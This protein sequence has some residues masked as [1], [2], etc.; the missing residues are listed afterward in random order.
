MRQQQLQ[1]AL[2]SISKIQDRI[3]G[4]PCFILLLFDLL[5][6]LTPHSSLNKI[7]QEKNVSI[8]NNTSQKAFH[9]HY[10]LIKLLISKG[11]TPPYVTQD[12]FCE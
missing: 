9:L 4:R 1:A 12:S 2:P 8:S 10:E 11:L 7:K 3:T 5:H 6:K